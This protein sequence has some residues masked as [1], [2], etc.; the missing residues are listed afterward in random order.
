MSRSKKDHSTGQ[1][2][3]RLSGLGKVVD[4]LHSP[5]RTFVF[6]VAIV[7][8]L[9]V[10]WA[11]T[12]SKVRTRVLSSPEYWLRIQNVEITQLPEWIHTDVR[13]EVFRDA[14]L[15]RPLSIVDDDL[16]ERIANAFKLHPWVAEVRQVRKQHP[17]RVVVDLTYYRPVLMVQVRHGV[18]EGL[19]AVDVN[20]VLLPSEGNFLPLEAYRYPRLVGIDTVPVGPAGERWGDARVVGAAGIA[21]CFG[22][23]WQRLGLEKIVPADMVS[24][25]RHREDTYEI[26]TAGGK[27]ILWGRAPTTDMPEELPAEEK[28]ARLVKY[29]AEHGALDGPNGPPELDVRGLQAVNSQPRTAVARPRV[30]HR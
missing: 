20:G 27:R 1:S 19:L 9:C 23:A 12:W 8:V 3:L 15:D 28:V 14:S 2:L 16:A 22:E 4:L 26:Y 18:Q 10:A 13:A 11:A 30:I 24:V 17:A 7:A 6:A 21:A 29:A 5:Y 25:G